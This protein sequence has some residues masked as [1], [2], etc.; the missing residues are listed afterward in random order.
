MLKALTIFLGED[1][2]DLIKEYLLYVSTSCQRDTQNILDLVYYKREREI[3][4][5]VRTTIT[6][7]PWFDC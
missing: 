2:A 5:T 7:E 1:A 6:P 3:F 4:S